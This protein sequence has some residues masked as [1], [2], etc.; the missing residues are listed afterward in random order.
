MRKLVASCSTLVLAAA[1]LAACGSSGSSKANDSAV[2]TNA[3]SPA[4]SE[5]D[6]SKLVANAN[7]QKFK[8]TYT[9]GSGTSQTYEQDGNGNSVYG[10]DGSLTFVAKASI[11]NC[12]KSSGSYQCTATPSSQGNAASPFSG[13]VTALQS[14]LSALGGRFGSTS[15][16]TIAG[17]EAECVTFSQSDLVGSGSKASYTGCIDKQTGTTLEFAVDNGGRKTTSLLVTKFESPGASDFTPPVTPST[18]PSNI[19]LPD[20]ASVTLPTTPGG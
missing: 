6:L 20:A 11:V 4:P 12:D 16:K 9:D 19:S 3:G 18:Y 13:I 15:T 7:K 1:V 10:S 17:R 5:T 2:T 14:Q 8:I